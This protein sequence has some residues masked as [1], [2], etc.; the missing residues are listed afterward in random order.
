M[1]FLI[2]LAVQTAPLP[3]QAP[4]MPSAEDFTRPLLS[5]DCA[6]ETRDGAHGRLAFATTGGRAFVTEAAPEDAGEPVAAGIRRT[7][8]ILHVRA[9]ELGLLTDVERPRADMGS[10]GGDV[11]FRSRIFGAPRPSWWRLVTFIDAHRGAAHDT[12]TR[13]AELVDSSGRAGYLS[14][15]CTIDSTP[16]PPLAPEEIVRESTR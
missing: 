5:V 11:S 15:R 9:D 7:P 10:H 8:Q 16:Q 1:V 3:P 2:A 14:G 12:Q 4:R 6:L 13:R